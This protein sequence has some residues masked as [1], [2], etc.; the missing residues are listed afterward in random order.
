M[1]EAPVALIGRHVDVKYHEET[2][3]KAEVIYKNKSF[4]FLIPVDLSVN[5]RVKRD[6]WRNDIHIFPEASNYKGGQLL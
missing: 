6:K 5:C 3:K 4:G 1:F 2:P